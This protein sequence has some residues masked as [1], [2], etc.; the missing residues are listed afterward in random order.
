MRRYIVVETDDVADLVKELIQQDGSRDITVVVS[1]AGSALPLAKSIALARQAPVALI[2]DA[3]TDNPILL[4]EQEREYA[5]I[6][7]IVPLAT[8]IT[9]MLG[10]P[11]VEVSFKD[12]S[13]SGEISAF[14]QRKDFD[15]G[16]EAVPLPLSLWSHDG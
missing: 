10:A 13:W 15:N 4:D 1:G 16:E 9:L 6:F 11:T 3:N 7:R 5:E 2:V 12:P 14:I 8:P